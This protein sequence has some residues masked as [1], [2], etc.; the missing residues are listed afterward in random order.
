MQISKIFPRVWILRILN[1]E[2][3][4]IEVKQDIK[5]TKEKIFKELKEGT[6]GAG[7]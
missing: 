4:L 6:A 5:E 1:K 2:S 3:I 7:N